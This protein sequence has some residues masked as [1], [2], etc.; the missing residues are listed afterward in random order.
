ML[1][2]IPHFECCQSIVR[3]DEVSTKSNPERVDVEKDGAS[4]SVRVHQSLIKEEEFEPE[5]DADNS[6]MPE[7][8]FFQK[9]PFSPNPSVKAKQ[10]GGHTRS[11]GGCQK[12][13][14]PLI[15]DFD[16]YDITAPEKTEQ[17]QQ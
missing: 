16:A 3:E 1:I 12:G 15:A 13:R 2:P 6:S 4:R 8:L 9:H 14:D 5:E 7:I 17:H 11:Y 10:P